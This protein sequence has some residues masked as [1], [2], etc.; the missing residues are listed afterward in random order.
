MLKGDNFAKNFE[1]DLHN[2]KIDDKFFKKKL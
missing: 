1:N 2:K